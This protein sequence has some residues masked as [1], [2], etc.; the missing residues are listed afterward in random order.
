M[1]YSR[2]NWQDDKTPLSANN[3][4]HMDEAIYGLSASMD[5]FVIGGKINGSSV[6]DNSLAGTKIIIGSVEGNRLADGSITDS[7][8]KNGSVIAGKLGQNSVLE[9]NISP[10]AVTTINIKDG[11]VTT[12]KLADGAVVGGKITDRTVTSTKISSTGISEGKTLISDGSGGVSWKDV[13]IPTNVVQK[14]T[15][16]GVQYTSVSGNVTIVQ[17]QADFAENNPSS[18]SFINNK[19]AQMQLPNPTS[20]DRNKIVYVNAS[21]QYDLGYPNEYRVGSQWSIKADTNGLSIKW[22]GG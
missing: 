6:S 12:A 9:G 16:N 2:V 8:I 19:P 18:P 21:S 10:N 17:A 5:T 3:L 20:E 15:Y 7:K 4:N 11:S 14:I 13:S 1:S 22:I